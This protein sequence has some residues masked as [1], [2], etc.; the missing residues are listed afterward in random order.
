MK[1]SLAD[2]RVV[3]VGVDFV[4]LGEPLDGVVPEPLAQGRR[5]LH[6]HPPHRVGRQEVEDGELLGAE[7]V[8]VGAVPERGEGGSEWEV[9]VVVVA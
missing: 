9:V 1:H 2:P 3:R 8:R 7:L 6:R 5:L 4:R